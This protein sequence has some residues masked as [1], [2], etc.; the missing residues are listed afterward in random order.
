MIFIGIVMLSLVVSFFSSSMIFDKKIKALVEDILVEN[1]E[2]IIQTYK[3]NSTADIVPFMESISG[4]ASTRL[5]LYDKDKKQLLGENETIIP[6]D[7]IH[8]KNVLNGKKVSGIQVVGTHI[9]IVGVPFEV[10]GI[11]YGL[12]L[13]VEKNSV[14][15]E[16]MNSIHLMYILIFFFGS[17][18]ILIASRYIVNPIIRLTEATKL[19]AKGNF[20]LE[21][22]IKRRDEIGI[23]SNGFNE[24]AK[25]LS[26]LDRMRKDFVA[27]VS[28][29]MQSPLTSI[30]GFS[31]ALKQK[32]MSEENRIH[33]LNI[34]E[35]ESERLSRLSQNLLR[36][37]Y[38]Q[39]E[40][41]P[42]RLSV[43]RL[44]EQLRKVVIGL[45]PQWRSKEIEIN[46]DLQSIEIQS[47]E[48]Q[49]QQVWI[50]LLT[51]SIKFTPVKGR[52]MIDIYVK[53]D[54][55]NISITDNGIGIP[56]DEQRDIFKPFH[57]VD[58]ARNSSS[59]G[60]GLGLSI[61]KQIVD[62]HNGQIK[63]KGGLGGGTTFIV[64]LP[65]KRNVM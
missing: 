65:L 38:L 35:E 57:K 42:L 9:P 64:S 29:E 8:I 55:V 13:T 33:Y 44:D 45:E 4:L 54:H 61:V 3:L 17:F 32:K 56:E 41:Y 39:Q 7:P 23:L 16:I 52:I 20:E 18:L 51:N 53:D 31:K 22:P 12:F 5:Q 40:K 50:N 47:D 49:L 19:M 63:I 43:F 14:E 62:I 28:H 58:K 27:N 11:R 15:E 46:I 59:K 37:S 34:I 60:S 36:L 48:D 24:M 10:N 25:E 26:K 1:G 6:I 2:K 30:K 21:L